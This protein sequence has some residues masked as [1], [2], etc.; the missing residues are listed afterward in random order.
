MMVIEAVSSIG[1]EL[2]QYSLGC[3]RRSQADIGRCQCGDLHRV[4]APG[5]TAHPIV[6]CAELRRNVAAA[7]Q[8]PSIRRSRLSVTSADAAA[9]AVPIRSADP[10]GP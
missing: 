2:N 3:A 9:S 8:Q 1:S 5:R 6:G 7:G 10:A 4:G